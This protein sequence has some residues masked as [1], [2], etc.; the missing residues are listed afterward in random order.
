MRI[1]LLFCLLILAACNPTQQRAATE[2][3][4]I[5]PGTPELFVTWVQAGNLFV[6]QQGEA[7]VRQI[8]TGDVVRPRFA[9]DG[10]HIAFTRGA[11]HAEETLWVI[12]V[13]GR[14]ETPFTGDDRPAGY[15]PGENRIANFA[16]LDAETLIFNTR[17]GPPFFEEQND[18]YRLNMQSGDLQQLLAPGAG[19]RFHISPDAAQIAVT[20]AGEYSVNNGRI[21]V[22]DA[23]GTRP[24]LD[25]LSFVGVAT[26]SENPFHPALHWLP[27][28]QTILTAIPDSDLIYSD[29]A[30]SLPPTT[31]WR[32]SLKEPQNPQEIGP[33][34][35]SIFGLPRWS[36]SGTMMTYLQRTPAT[37]DFTLMAARG[38][39]TQAS[40]LFTGQ[41]DEVEQPRWLPDSD[42]QFVYTQ[43][44]VGEV[45]IGG[46]QIQ[47][48][49]LS[50]ENILQP[51]FVNAT[52]YVYAALDSGGIE[53]RFA[54]LEGESQRIAAVGDLVPIFDAV[55]INT[56]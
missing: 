4:T 46:P 32:L 8:A 3:A 23:A 33:V 22:I 55:L 53:L 28:N 11:E 43:N 16:W 35:A 38:D 49:R 20:F 6:W 50:S 9:P 29:T 54:E 21:R 7:S 44:T 2:S 18:L 41:I 45:Y 56:V 12:A 39:G 40:A 48:Q 25:L 42:S 27:D 13:N 31:L 37:N 5:A 36:A 34:V 15:K 19:G 24:P 10:Q 14:D 51:L 1:F 17:S 30:A 47:A 26:G 52:I